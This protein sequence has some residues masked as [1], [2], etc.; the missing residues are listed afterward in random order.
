MRTRILWIIAGVAVIGA[1][2]WGSIVSNVEQT[3]YEVVESHGD[4]QI[5]DYASMIVA[6][7]EV[8]GERKEAINQGFRGNSWKVHFVMPASYSLGTLP[9]PNNDAVKLE[10]VPGKRF[11]VIRF[12]GMAGE[13]RPMNSEKYIIAQS[14]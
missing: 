8:S 7:A 4:I 13:D 12:S 6:E 10:K 14:A 9:K 1:A 3:K 11:T 2:T 5:R